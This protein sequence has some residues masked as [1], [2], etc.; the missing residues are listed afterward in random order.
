MSSVKDDEFK[1]SI[2]KVLINLCERSITFSLLVP[3]S[4]NRAKTSES[5][6][7]SIPLLFNLS[8]GL[9]STLISFNLN[10]TTSLL[11]AFYFNVVKQIYCT[12]H[13]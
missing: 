8:R 13:L 9:W 7:L 10:T 4:N 3:V 12:P 5:F 6:K 2:P 1:L 11:F